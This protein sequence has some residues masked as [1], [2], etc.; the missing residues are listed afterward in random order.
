MNFLLTNTCWS[1]NISSWLVWQAL[2]QKIKLIK[3]LAANLHIGDWPMTEGNISSVFSTQIGTNRNLFDQDRSVMTTYTC[4]CVCLVCQLFCIL[5]VLADLS[6]HRHTRFVQHLAHS[7]T[8][9]TKWKGD[10]HTNHRQ[11]KTELRNGMSTKNKNT[12]TV[13]ECNRTQSPWC[14]LISCARV[15]RSKQGR[16]SRS[17]TRNS[18]FLLCLRWFFVTTHRFVAFRA[19]NEF[20]RSSK[21]LKLCETKSFT[22]TIW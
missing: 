10:K 12:H 1:F 3:K 6:S 18:N 22:K 13:A 15:N 21:K 16:R 20:C 2:E 17:H 7:H 8:R 9:E 4:E 5:C 14:K 11:S 19:D